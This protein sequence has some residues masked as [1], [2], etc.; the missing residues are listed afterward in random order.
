M[1]RRKTKV[2]E[3]LKT[4][5]VKKITINSFDKKDAIIEVEAENFM[6][7]IKKE[8]DVGLNPPAKP[9]K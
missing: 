9:K 7:R 1:A 4:T 2:S 3:Q 8:P 6:E 5:P